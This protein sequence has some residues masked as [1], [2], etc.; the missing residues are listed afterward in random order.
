MPRSG[1]AFLIEEAG[2]LASDVLR[3]VMSRPRRRP[4]ESATEVVTTTPE[5]TT[6]PIPTP[7]P[8]TPE[9]QRKELDYRYECVLKH[10]GESS[11]V[12]REAYERAL[13]EGMG[14]GT[15]EKIM[16]CL[17][18]HATAE[19]DIEKML[20]IP[21]GKEIAERLLSG[22]RQFRA[23]AWK[24]NM[25]RG[26]GTKEDIEAARMWNAILYQEAYSAVMKFPGEECIKEGM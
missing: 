1:R 2:N 14:E 13:D 5:T 9:A 4:V 20:P 23:A 6:T 18:A 24:T 25:P 7:P 10:L 15:A 17:N 8:V 3:A 16:E 11:G 19:P 12:L 21:E 26:K 22:I